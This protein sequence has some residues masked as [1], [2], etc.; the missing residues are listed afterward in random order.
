MRKV[1]IVA[2]IAVAL[3]AA[4]AAAMYVANPA[5]TLPAAGTSPDRPIVVKF[6]ARWCPVCMV[7]KT[8]WDQ[9]QATYADRVHLTAFD[10]TNDATTAA[11]RVEARRLGLESFLDEY[12]GTTGSVFI[13]DGRTRTVRAEL[14]GN[15]DF[16]AYRD[17]IEAALRD[18]AGSPHPDK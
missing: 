9:L 4:A 13:L 14:P 7:T 10:F 11:T 17:A 12:M 8:A 5:P 6:H 18:A 16:E 2:G 1:S 15:R 3:L